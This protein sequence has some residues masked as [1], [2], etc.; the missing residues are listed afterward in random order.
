MNFIING[1]MFLCMSAIAGIGFLIKYTLI[2]GQKRWIIY[3]DNVE[4]YLL[5]LD[6][7]EWGT[8]HLIIGY[9]LL[10]LI[11]IHIIFHLKTI[12]SVYNKIFQRKLINRLISI[13]F[14]TI[15]VLFLIV[16]LLIH[17]TIG[18]L[19][20]GKGR[21]NVSY[22]KHMDT[23]GSTISEKVEL[24]NTE[25]LNTSPHSSLSLEIRGYMTLNEISNKYKVPI[26]FIKTKLKIPAGVSSEKK[27]SWIRK[28]YNIT[29]NDVKKTITEYQNKIE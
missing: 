19:E 24:I 26:E 18:K 9:V 3:N 10:G 4:L 16:P 12:S 8:I 14:I 25:T 6:R 11:I 1:F 22:N 23:G 13:L 15:C 2:S 20:H 28:K 17:P 21:L 5:R 7:H 29:M 27:L